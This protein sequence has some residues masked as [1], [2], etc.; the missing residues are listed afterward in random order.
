[1]ARS[2][3]QV[4]AGRKQSIVHAIRGLRL[5]VREE[6]NARVHVAATLLAVLAGSTAHVS[7]AEWRWLALACA[8]VWSAEAFNTAIERVCDRLS[9]DHD[10]LIGA[11]KDVAAG[12]VLVAAL[13]AG[14]IG[15]SIFL[16]HLMG[17]F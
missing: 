17:F 4:V 11:A 8:L 1:M 13:A 9:R 16:P 2:T 15:A 6:A 12:A 5:L 7:F 10:P 14:A 3:A